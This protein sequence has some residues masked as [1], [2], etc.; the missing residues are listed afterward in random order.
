M[1]CYPTVL[2]PLANLLWPRIVGHIDRILSKEGLFSGH[3]VKARLV[4]GV[5]KYSPFT[6]AKP[7]PGLASTPACSKTD[8]LAPPLPIYPV[9]T[10]RPEH[11]NWVANYDASPSDCQ[12]PLRS[13]FGRFYDQKKVGNN[14]FVGK[15]RALCHCHRQPQTT[16][17]D[18]F[19]SFLCSPCSRQDSIG[20][21][22]IPSIATTTESPLFVVEYL[23][24]LALGPV[25]VAT[26]CFEY[27]P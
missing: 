15:G 6:A 11:G 10:L 12:K 20:K 5:G 23:N 19:G 1:G 8:R 14:Y 4:A 17:A 26:L 9:I 22:W 2:L 25:G 27:S 21:S 16:N 3:K 7:P 24:C 18:P 13:Q